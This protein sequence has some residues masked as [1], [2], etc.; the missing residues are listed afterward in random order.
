[1][2]AISNPARKKRNPQPKDKTSDSPKVDQTL[3]SQ[4]NTQSDFSEPASSGKSENLVQ[5]YL[6]E[7]KR[8]PLLKAE[9]E[10]TLA[11]RIARLRM[12]FRRLTLS[13]PRILNAFIE[14]A[15]EVLR[16][17]RKID[18]L[19]DVPPNDVAEKKHLFQLL[20][21]HLPTIQRLLDQ[22]N[23]SDANKRRVHLKIVRLFEEL[24]IRHEQYEVML[25]SHCNDAQVRFKLQS[26]Q[27]RYRQSIESLIRAN[28]RLVVSIAKKYAYHGYDLLDVVQEG[29]RGLLRAVS[30]FQVERGLKFSTYATWW[31]RQAILK[32]IPNSGRTIRI[33][34]QHF[35]TA[36]KIDQAREMLWK[37]HERN[38]SHEEVFESLG[39]SPRSKDQLRSIIN[40]TISIEQKPAGADTAFKNI[41][42]DQSSAPLRRNVSDTIEVASLLKSL[43]P[44]ERRTIELRFGLDGNENKSLAEVGRLLGLTRERIRQIE[45]N[46]IDKMRKLV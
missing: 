25:F 43:N 2:I 5:I 39:Y 24:Q 46:A 17:E 41:L 4:S 33:P 35:S 40:D 38:P 26:L 9:E 13:D 6:Q 23:D 45:R 8:T 19:M 10:K 32:K 3:S 29:N 1:M 31:I 7:V 37:Q 14:Q 16:G 22:S 42:M 30:K 15:T 27:N 44:S 12:A 36:R 18:S 20:S 28:L 11:R 34:E 21:I